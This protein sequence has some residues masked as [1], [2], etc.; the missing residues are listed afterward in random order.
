VKGDLKQHIVDRWAA[1]EAC[2]MADL[3]AGTLA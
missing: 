3:H 2:G 1:G